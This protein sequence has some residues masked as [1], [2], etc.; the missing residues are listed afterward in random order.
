VGG[1]WVTMRSIRFVSSSNMGEPSLEVFSQGYN[2]SLEVDVSQLAIVFQNYFLVDLL[3]WVAALTAALAPPPTPVAA[4]ATTPLPRASIESR[5]GPTGATAA[6]PATAM[7]M[8]VS[9]AAP[10][11]L[12]PADTHRGDSLEV[13]PPTSH[14]PFRPSTFE[15]RGDL[16]RVFELRCSVSQ[17]YDTS[18]ESLRTV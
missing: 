10:V 11:I 15:R 13:E 17:R 5:S 14:L 6:A 12:M 3:Q 7:K 1:Y 4:A 9:L 8:V 18:A 2:S 16:C